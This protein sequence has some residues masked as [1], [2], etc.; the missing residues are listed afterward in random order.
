[1]FNFKKG[2][3][4]EGKER[5][6]NEAKHFIVFISGSKEVPNGIIMTHKPHE[7]VACNIKLNNKYKLSKKDNDRDSY[8]VAHLIEKVEDWGPYKKINKISKKDLILINSYIKGTPITWSQ[9]LKYTK[10]GCH[11]HRAE[12]NN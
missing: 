2:D 6:Y 5:G 12:L 8:F 3:I 4:L 9:Y 1:M 11:E 7:E 10:D